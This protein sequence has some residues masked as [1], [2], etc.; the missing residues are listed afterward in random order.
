MI[1]III[2][3]TE[4]K[5]EREIATKKKHILNTGIPSP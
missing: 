1:I 3:Y 5:K 4:R 2:H